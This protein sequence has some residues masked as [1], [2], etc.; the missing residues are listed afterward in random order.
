VSKALLI[1]PRPDVLIEL[2]SLL[3][4]QDPDI[5]YLIKVIKQDVALYTILLSVAN[6]PVYRRVNA[7]TSIDQAVM[8]L[9]CVKVNTL[10]QAVVVR[11]E[12]QQDDL[13]EEF[14][15]SAT[16]VASICSVI[17]EQFILV[18]PELAYKVGMLHAAGTAVMMQNFPN[19]SKFLRQNG[20][21]ASKELC[22]LERNTFA[23]DHYQQGFELAKNWN[24]DESAALAV[25][26]QPITM[27]VIKDHKHLP[28]E[29]PILLALLKLAK[30]LSNEYR[31][32][33]QDQE[34]CNESNQ[35]L[36]QIL[37]YLHISDDD[38]KDLREQLSHQ[39]FQCDAA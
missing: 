4:T 20:H 7:I 23:T 26:Y 12:L 16:E 22:Y 1:P 9:G 35:Q 38:Y 34:A 19:Y 5:N 33:W 3:Q 24:M 39:L 37:N 18:D 28:S 11:S 27:A 29:V 2:Q 8:I 36:K 6:S 25:R 21:L 10:I 15:S 31:R 30:S 13:Y 32:Y 14:W 17:A